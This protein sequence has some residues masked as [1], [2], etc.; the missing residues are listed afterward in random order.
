MAKLQVI[1]QKVFFHGVEVAELK[2]PSKE[3]SYS[4]AEEFLIEFQ[5]RFKRR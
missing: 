3:L 1:D 5:K 4:E 2:L